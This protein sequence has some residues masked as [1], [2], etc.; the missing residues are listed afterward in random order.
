MRARE[1]WRP[2]G[3]HGRSGVVLLFERAVRAGISV[4]S[5]LVV[6]ATTLHSSARSV[7][8]RLL[9][10]GVVAGPVNPSFVRCGLFLRLLGHLC[11]TTTLFDPNPY[12]HE[13]RRP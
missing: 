9:C 6:A 12:Y 7:A 5:L 11:P 3:G 1:G 8:L 10:N 13:S 2:F 4:S